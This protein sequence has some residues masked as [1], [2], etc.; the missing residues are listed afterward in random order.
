[1]NTSKPS[2]LQDLDARLAT[3]ETNLK[4]AQ[5]RAQE[6]GQAELDL[7]AAQVLMR[8]FQNDPSA[9][10][11]RRPRCAV[12]CSEVSTGRSAQSLIERKH[13]ANLIKPTWHVAAQLA[14]EL[15]IDTPCLCA[16]KTIL[17]ATATEDD[18]GKKGRLHNS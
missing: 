12:R 5:N 13:H 15:D 3:L 8:R 1:M 7:E 16:P 10:A 2:C 6:R 11:D 14:S 9:R 18:P 17:P 4:T